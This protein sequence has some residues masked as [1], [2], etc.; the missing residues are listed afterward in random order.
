MERADSELDQACRCV[1]HI[2]ET[3]QGALRIEYAVS[4]RHDEATIGPS[5][6]LHVIFE[7]VGFIAK[8]AALTPRRRANRKGPARP[9][10]TEYSPEHRTG[11]AAYRTTA[12]T[13]R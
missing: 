1:A 7:P 5:G 11:G 4:R 10:T 9:G 13:E 12:S 6:V 2:D 8:F 3:R